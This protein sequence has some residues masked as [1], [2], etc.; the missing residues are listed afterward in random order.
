MLIVWADNADAISNQYSGTGAL[1]TDFTRLGKRTKIGALTDLKNSMVRYIKNHYYDG[2]R[3]D[4]FDLFH[5]IYQ[6]TPGDSPLDGGNLT[7]F[8]IVVLLIGH[9]Q[10]SV[11]YAIDPVQP[12][13]S[14]RVKVAIISTND[15]TTTFVLIDFTTWS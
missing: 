8:R 15:F 7:I 11:F 3:Q 5:G 1:K 6:V 13:V 12:I 10:F 2:E 14:I 9:Y 4:G